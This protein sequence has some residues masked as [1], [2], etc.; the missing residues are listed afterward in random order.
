VLKAIRRIELSIDLLTYESLPHNFAGKSDEKEVYEGIYETW[1]TKQAI[2]SLNDKFKTLSARFNY[3]STFLA[4]KAQRKSNIIQWL[5]NI[6]VFFLTAVTIISVSSDIYEYKYGGKSWLNI[7]K[8]ATEIYTP[9]WVFMLL[10]L[11]SLIILFVV[12]KKKFD[13]DE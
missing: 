1:E 12:V 3:Y 6:W 9:L 2:D 11:L 10:V 8:D 4:D 5:I 7:A 13:K